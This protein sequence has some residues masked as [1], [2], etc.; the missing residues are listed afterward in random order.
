MAFLPS[1]VASIPFANQP[2]PFAIAPKPSPIPHVRAIS[3]RNC[4]PAPNEKPDCCIMSP[5]NSRLKIPRLDSC[6]GLLKIAYLSKIAFCSSSFCISS[7]G[8]PASACIKDSSVPIVRKALPTSA[9]PF[10]PSI[11]VF[12][13]SASDPPTALLITSPQ[14]C[15]PAYFSS[16]A[17][18]DFPSIT[19]GVA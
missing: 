3:E 7:S 15:T 11:K 8:D 16:F 13:A 17:S 5:T 12:L 1:S 6:T 14:V 10:Q 18:Y 9:Q 4:A 19:S 2:A